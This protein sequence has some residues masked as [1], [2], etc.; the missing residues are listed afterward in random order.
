MPEPRPGFEPGTF[1]IPRGCAA[2]APSRQKQEITLASSQ[3]SDSNRGPAAY[4]T[5]ALPLSYP[6]EGAGPR[7]HHRALLGVVS[8]RR[9]GTGCLGGPNP[10]L[11]SPSR[12]WESNPCTSAY[13]ADALASE[14][15][16]HCPLHCR[17]ASPSR[18]REAQFRFR[19]QWAASRGMRDSNPPI[20]FGRLVPSPSWL[21][22]HC[23]QS[24][25]IRCCVHD[26]LSAH[27]PAQCPLWVTIPVPAH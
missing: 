25:S 13:K 9:M 2:V 24:G 8:S 16:R 3:D 1:P 27:G 7:L 14:L 6:G 12:P 17:R 22:P 23:S 10:H 20:Q 18:S 26:R 4:E 15:E 11:C 5:A 19:L 21:I